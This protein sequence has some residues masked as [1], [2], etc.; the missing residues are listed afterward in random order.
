MKLL[1]EEEC[2]TAGCGIK[3]GRV[4]KEGRG[5]FVTVIKHKKVGVLSSQTNAEVVW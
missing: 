5:P 1:H 4:R 2:Q 3:G